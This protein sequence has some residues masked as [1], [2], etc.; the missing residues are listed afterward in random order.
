MKN[1]FLI[2]IISIFVFV[3][4][5]LFALQ[6]AMP[7]YRFTALETGNCVMMLLSLTAYFMVNNQLKKNASAFVRGVSGASFLKLM[8]CLIAMTIYIVVNRTHIHKPSV[9]V[10]MGIYAIYAAAETMLLSKM[11]RVMK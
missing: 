4:G 11:A 1:T 7:E 9:F 10:L 3:S 8:V 6:S 5:T 2:V